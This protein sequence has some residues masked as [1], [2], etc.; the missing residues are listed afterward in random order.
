MWWAYTAIIPF[1]RPLYITALRS[2]HELRPSFPVPHFHCVC[3]LYFMSQYKFYV[4]SAAASSQQLQN[5]HIY[6]CIYRLLLTQFSGRVI[7]VNCKILTYTHNKLVRSEW[8]HNIIVNEKTGKQLSH[9]EPT[10]SFYFKGT[11]W[12]WWLVMYTRIM[13]HSALGQTP[14]YSSSSSSSAQHSSDV[15]G[16][17]H[18]YLNEIRLENVYN[19]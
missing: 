19:T 1:L 2:I 10:Y 16:V 18:Q 9:K 15:C 13:V 14:S 12:W 8:I 4:C 17:C 3:L 6:L 11:R 7:D 5:S